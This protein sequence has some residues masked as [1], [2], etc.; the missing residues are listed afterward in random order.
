[1][2][3]HRINSNVQM[4]T[5]WMMAHLLERPVLAAAVREEISVAMKASESTESTF[6]DTLA[7]VVRRELVPCCPLLNSAFNE[8][9]GVHS[10]GSTVARL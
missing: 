4:T 7:E 9:S 3:M 6:G 1:M 8:V 2:L 5:F 10:T